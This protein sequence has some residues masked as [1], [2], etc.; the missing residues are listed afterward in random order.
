M[1]LAQS[2]LTL[3]LS[4]FRGSSCILTQEVLSWQRIARLHSKKW[5]MRNL[6]SNSTTITVCWHVYILYVHRY[7]FVLRGLTLFSRSFLCYQCSAGW[8]TLCFWAIY[9]HRVCK[10]RRIRQMQWRLALKL[11]SHI[12]R[13]KLQPAQAMK[14]IKIHQAQAKQVEYQI[15]SHEKPR[16]VIQFCAMSE[17]DPLNKVPQPAGGLDAKMGF[18]QV[19][20][21]GVTLSNRSTTKELSM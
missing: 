14:R 9:L 7:N 6:L 3:F 4:S 18:S 5:R 2:K 8:Q 10:G 20:R 16:A 19:P 12:I 17:L 21:I 1:L 11:P 13:S 15:R